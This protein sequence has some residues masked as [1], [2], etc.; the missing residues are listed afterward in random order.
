MANKYRYKAVDVALF[1]STCMGECEAG[2]YQQQEEGPQSLLHEDGVTWG[3]LT[4]TLMWVCVGD[5][6]F[7]V[8]VTRRHK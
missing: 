4:P 7:R 6:E 3:F 2:G 1:I 8:R 5:Q